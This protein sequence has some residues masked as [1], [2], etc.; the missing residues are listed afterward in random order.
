[1]DATH[2]EHR[3]RVRYAETDQ[4]GIVHHANYLMY[5][6]ESRTSLM[7]DRGCS[8]AELER[9]GWALP[10]RKVQMR[11]R[12]PA[13]YEE[14]LV[15]RTR[16]GRV[17]NASITFE[18]DVVRPADGTTVASGSIELACVRKDASVRRPLPLPPE[19]LERLAGQDAAGGPPGSS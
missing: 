2:H 7:R 16:V 6:E 5:L 10:V 9:R 3:L 4:M 18:S 19:L 17:G 13:Y 1:M 14:E 11:Y 8:Y 12:A 15:V